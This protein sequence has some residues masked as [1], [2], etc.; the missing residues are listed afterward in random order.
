MTIQAPSVIAN[1]VKQSILEMWNRT[2]NM[3]KIKQGVFYAKQKQISENDG[4]ID[5]CRTNGIG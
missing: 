2:D 1:E 4:G 5:D 3:G